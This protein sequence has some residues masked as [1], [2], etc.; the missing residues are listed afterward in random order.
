MNKKKILLMVGVLG[1]I[2][3]ILAIV[4]VARVYFGLRGIPES[5]IKGNVPD[6]V[7]FSEYL[8]R[9]LSAYFTKMMKIEVNADYIL[10]QDKP[11]QVGVGAPKF[12]I[13]VYVKNNTSGEIIDSGAARVGA[14]GKEFF[15]IMNYFSKNEIKASPGRLNNI[16][17]EDVASKIIKE[18]I[19]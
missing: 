15:T 8:S 17:P 18:F 11:A 9:D 16:F 7:F 6:E 14:N 13:W 3:I 10:L 12:Y 2:S 19:N 5:H 1:G 4:V